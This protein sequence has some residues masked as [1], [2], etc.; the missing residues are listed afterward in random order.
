MRK[1]ATIPAVIMGMFL[2]I[3]VAGSY[4]KTVPSD[5]AYCQESDSVSAHTLEEVLAADSGT[6]KGQI[7]IYFLQYF[8]LLF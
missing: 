5:L 2:A 4:G 8:Y 3:M 1:K 6:E 7:Q